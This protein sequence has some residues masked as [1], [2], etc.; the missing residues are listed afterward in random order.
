MAAGESLQQVHA[1]LDGDTGV[2]CEFA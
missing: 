1:T 2:R